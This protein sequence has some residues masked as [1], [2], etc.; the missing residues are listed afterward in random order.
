[1]RENK[2]ITLIALIVTIIILIILA[3]ISIHFIW[4]DNGIIK[5]AQEARNLHEIAEIKEQLEFAVLGVQ[6]DIL[7]DI[8]REELPNLK[9]ITTESVEPKLEKSM[10]VNIGAIQNSVGEKPQ[11]IATVTSNGKTYS[12]VIQEDMSIIN[13]DKNDVFIDYVVEDYIGTN[14]KIKLTFQCEGGIK[15]IILP[16][17][18][19]VQGN[20]EKIITQETQLKIATDCEYIVITADGIQKRKIVNIQGNIDKIY[21]Y[22][23]GEKYEEIT[24]GWEAV[25]QS[26]AD[27][28]IDS[29]PYIDM[30]SW[31]MDWCAI[32]L[33]SKKTISMDF[34]QK[35][36][37][38][39][40]IESVGSTSFGFIFGVQKSKITNATIEINSGHTQGLFGENIELSVDTS[41][42]T[43]EYYVG[44]VAGRAH[45]KIHEIWLEHIS[46]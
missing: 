32:F 28:N 21:L 34:V 33:T 9:D 5:R 38:K 22:K 20:G 24:G 1:M 6:T 41:G 18:T 36:K 3:T 42:I 11:K 45:V 35:L 2:G 25:K 44:A 46:F 13:I 4:S 7:Q 14:L 10:N 27:F 16:D 12:F 15:E 30:H 43:G 31:N 29:Y 40:N 8:T 37:M 39:I 17:G 23:E 26:N 19:K